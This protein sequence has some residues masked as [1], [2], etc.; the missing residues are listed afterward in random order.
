M[1]D[2]YTPIAHRGEIREIWTGLSTKWSPHSFTD[3]GELSFRPLEEPG[4]IL[5]W[6]SKQRRPR[7][8]DC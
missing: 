8:V 4:G 7:R 6:S 1:G 3:L 2:G 5:D